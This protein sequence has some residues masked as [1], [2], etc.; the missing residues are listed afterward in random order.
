MISTFLSASHFRPLR[1][2][3]M[4]LFVLGCRDA[5]ST[6]TTQDSS[7]TSP[8]SAVQSPPDDSTGLAFPAL[9]SH[10]DPH[11]IE[12]TAPTEIQF[13]D[14]AEEWGLQH[15]WPEQPRPMTAL[16]AFGAGCAAFDYDND[17]W[18]DVLL[19]ATPHPILFHNDGGNH[20]TNVTEQSGLKSRRELHCCPLESNFQRYGVTTQIVSHED[21]GCNLET[22]RP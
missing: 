17:G 9:K 16:D 10:R 11:R 12:I 19:V 3:A 18:Q 2:L 15:H 8:S 20:F 21:A 7:H 13:V 1:G 6:T 5:G 14:V 22:L 4:L